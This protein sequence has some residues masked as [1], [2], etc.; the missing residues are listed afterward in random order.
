[1]RT[2]IAHS[3]LIAESAPS[4]TPNGYHAYELCH[5][6]NWVMLFAN[7][8]SNHHLQTLVKSQLSHPSQDQVLVLPMFWQPKKSCTTTLKLLTGETRFTLTYCS[9][10]RMEG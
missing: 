4:S 9:K 10:S 2:R 6:E 7:D 1:L 3:V 8:G 5:V